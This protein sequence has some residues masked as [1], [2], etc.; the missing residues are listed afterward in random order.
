MV[1]DAVATGF[2]WRWDSSWY[3]ITNWHNVAGKNPSTGSDIGSFSPTHITF[4]IKHIH[5]KEGTST[6]FYPVKLTVTLYLNEEPLW[7]EHPAGYQIDCVALPIKIPH[8]IRLENQPFSDIGFAT[9]Y[10]P[11][12]GDDCFVV[13]FPKGLSGQ[14]D[15]PVWKRASIATEPS[16]NHDGQPL[17]L[18]D[19]AGRPGMS[20]S[21][22]IA[23]IQNLGYKPGNMGSRLGVVENFV[24]IYSGRTDDDELGVQIGRVWKSTVITEIVQGRRIGRHPLDIR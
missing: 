8:E 3:L 1:G 15:T 16:L 20:G 22:V 13:G 17:F 12:V 10:H 7:F 5:R 6:W 9:D 11:E 19:T 14:G 18:V 24:G 21:P 2:L 23:R 4:G